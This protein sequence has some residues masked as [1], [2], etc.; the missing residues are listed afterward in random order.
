MIYIIA[1]DGWFND[2]IYYSCK[3]YHLWLALNQISIEFN[4]V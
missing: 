2:H 3:I 4:W 1:D